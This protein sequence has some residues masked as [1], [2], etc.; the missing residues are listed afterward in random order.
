MEYP[1]KVWVIDVPLPFPFGNAQI[2]R[3]GP[4][5]PPPNLGGNGAKED[6]KGKKRR[7]EPKPVDPA[8]QSHSRWNLVFA[9]VLGP[10]YPLLTRWSFGNIVWALLGLAAI[11]A[12]AGLVIYRQQFTAAVENAELGLIPL[13]GGVSAVILIGFTAWARAVGI[14]GWKT[15][16]LTELEKR[17]SE[18]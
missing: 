17:L 7:G 6:A 1:K 13:V 11:A 9:Y 14:A 15:Q 16:R 5:L 4:A 8:A 18:D 10:I 2:R 3:E 12:C